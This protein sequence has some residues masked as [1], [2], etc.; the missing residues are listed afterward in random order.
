MGK[1]LLATAA[2]V[3]SPYPYPMTLAP[4]SSPLPFPFALPSSLCTA[5]LRNFG[6]PGTFGYVW[7]E[8]AKIWQ[9]DLRLRLNEEPSKG[10]IFANALARYC[11]TLPR[12]RN[13]FFLN[14][15]FFLKLVV[16]ALYIIYS[17]YIIFYKK[18]G[19]IL[20]F[21]NLAF[22]DWRSICPLSKII[23]F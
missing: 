8:T 3:P 19:I 5:R 23:I 22:V 13:F 10:P 11:E 9:R 20:A 2:G 6:S 17:V 4:P 16:Y 14:I 18:F 12:A 1:D 21:S 15:A 7:T